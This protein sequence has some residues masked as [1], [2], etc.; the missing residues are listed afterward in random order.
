[1]TV[2]KIVAE[3]MRIDRLATGS[4]LDDQVAD[5]LCRVRLHPEHRQRHPHA[6]SGGQR[7]RI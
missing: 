4:G 1:M 2:G 7:Q 6:F 3:P 5:I